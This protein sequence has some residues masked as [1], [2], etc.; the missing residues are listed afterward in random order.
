LLQR[1]CCTRNVSRDEGCISDCTFE[2][3]T[4]FFRHEISCFSA[5]AVPVTFQGMKAAFLIVPSNATHFSSVSVS[6]TRATFAVRRT[7]LRTR[8]TTRVAALR[9]ANEQLNTQIQE[10]IKNAEDAAKKYGKAS[11][12]AKVAW[13]FVEELEAERSHQAANKQSEDPLE[14]YCN[15]VPEADECR[16]YED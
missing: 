15:E 13:D 6:K 14:K 2:R 8:K 10:A 5:T 7:F 16:V 3:H 1:D 11:K 4:L 12:E 9:M